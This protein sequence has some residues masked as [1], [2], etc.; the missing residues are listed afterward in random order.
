MSVDMELMTAP[1][2]MDIIGTI[3]NDRVI[4]WALAG[5]GGARI[6]RSG[7][8]M[9]A[10]RQSSRNAHADVP[11]LLE[12]S[13]WVT[14]LPKRRALLTRSSFSQRDALRGSVEMMISS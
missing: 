11:T 14:G 6:G 4:S 13:T 10:D 9:R 7:A 2:T 3:Y 12:A 5:S 8:R 1:P